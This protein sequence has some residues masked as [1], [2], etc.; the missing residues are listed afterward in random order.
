MS[1]FSKSKKVK[2]TYDVVS[3][4]QECQIFLAEI[5]FD[6]FFWES[7]GFTTKKNLHQKA[8]TIWDIFILKTHW[9]MYIAL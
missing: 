3:D 2:V 7:A 8:H 6:E 9:T 1:C 5:L 4:F